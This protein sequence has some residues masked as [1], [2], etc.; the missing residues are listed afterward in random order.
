VSGVLSHHIYLE[1]EDAGIADMME[2][3]KQLEIENVFIVSS[4]KNAADV[5]GKVI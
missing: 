1:I 5:L 3:I 4:L 2:S